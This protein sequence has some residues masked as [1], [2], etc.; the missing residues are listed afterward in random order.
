METPSLLVGEGDAVGLIV[1]ESPK[2]GV[3]HMQRGWRGG[4]TLWV[5][6]IVAC[7]CVD[8]ELVSWVEGPVQRSRALH[9]SLAL[10]TLPRLPGAVLVACGVS[11]AGW[12]RLR[13][14]ASPQM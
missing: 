10:C 2:T 12:V 9:R 5:C 1:M 7:P 14:I 8:G 11:G 6:A 4:D 3:S 13:A